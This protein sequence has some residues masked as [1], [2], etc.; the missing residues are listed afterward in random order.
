MGPVQQRNQAR[1]LLEPSLEG[2]WLR[3]PRDGDPEGVH[4]RC[5][6]MDRS[7]VEDLVG[8]V[9]QNV[10]YWEIHL[11]RHAAGRIS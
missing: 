5:R 10:E 9:G 7:G 11:E 1:T 8:Q 3:V 6:H 2:A 4:S